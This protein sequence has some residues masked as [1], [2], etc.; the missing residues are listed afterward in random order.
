M[1]AG[2]DD[3]DD[4]DNEGSDMDSGLGAGAGAGAGLRR[5]SHRR[6]SARGMPGRPGHAASTRSSM[7]VRTYARICASL[8]PRPSPSHPLSHA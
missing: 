6:G 2:A 8:V 4:H 7:R 1:G 3:N 5:D